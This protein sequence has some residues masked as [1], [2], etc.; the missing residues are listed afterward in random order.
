M[1]TPAPFLPNRRTLVAGLD[2]ALNVN[3][4]GANGRHVTIL[5]RSLPWMISTVPNEVVRCRLPDGSERQM[6]LKYEAGHPPGA[7]GHRGNVTYEAEVYRRVLQHCPG[8]RPKFLGAHHAA[9]SDGTWLVLEYLDR[10]RRVIDLQVRRYLRQPRA[11]TDAA[12]WIGAF[13]AA[14]EAAVTRLE[15]GPLIRYDA[16]YFHGWAQ[17]TIEFAAPLLDGLPWLSQLYMRCSEWIE[18]LL[19]SPQTVIHGEFYVKNLLL[20]RGHVHV[21]DWESAAIGLGEI[22]LAAL[23]EG[24]WPLRTVARCESAYLR[25]RGIRGGR[26]MAEFQ[27]R[28]DAARIYLHFRWLGERPDW[29]VSEKADWRYRS[30][31]AA[32][33][34]LGL[35]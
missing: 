1:K 33:R 13:H 21:V 8:F 30:L 16:D 14:N 26:H 4:H 19:S 11:M 24:K 23:T 6:F 18:P 32:A 7:F 25:G 22:D 28:L 3:N 5:E 35:V 27:R 2:A 29:T 12:R 31:H 15:L 17:R 9:T 20:R 34:R 10:A